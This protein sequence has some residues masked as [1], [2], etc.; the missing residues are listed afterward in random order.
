M[1][2][3]P[4]RPY[5]NEHFGGRRGIQACPDLPAV[6][7]L[8]VIRKGTVAMRSR[9][10]YCSNVL[11]RDSL[12][13]RVQLRVL[14]VADCEHCVCGLRSMETF[15]LVCRNQSLE[16]LPFVTAWTHLH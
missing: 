15:F 7:I 10:Q 13:L 5:K 8:N 3:G 4:D 12:I 11:L 16:H 14:A 6:Y 9:Y 2:W 1:M